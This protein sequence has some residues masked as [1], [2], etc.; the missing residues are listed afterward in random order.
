MENKEDMGGNSRTY[1]MAFP[2]KAGPRSSPVEECSGQSATQTVIMVHFWYRHV[3]DT[4]VIMEEGNLPHPQFPMCDKLV[5]W[6]SQNGMHRCTVQCKTRTE[7][8][9]RCLAA[10]EER[11]VTSRAFIAYW[12]PLEMVTSFRYLERATLA[13]DE[14]WTAVVGDL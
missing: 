14:Y 8:N 4:I 3:R 11:E 12:T 2:V 5:P 10:E 9:Q 7:R 1:M 6:R 13:A